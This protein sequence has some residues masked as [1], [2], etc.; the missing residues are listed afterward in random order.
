MARTSASKRSTP[1]TPAPARSFPWG[2]VITGTVVVGSVA[3]IVWWE[4]LRAVA[5]SQ[6]PPAPPPPQVTAPPPVVAP[7]LTTAPP[8][9]VSLQNVRRFATIPHAAAA[10][11]DDILG[12]R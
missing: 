4:D 7:P 9:P 10:T 8:G 3:A 2:L 11:R 5:R 1:A 6:Q 12:I